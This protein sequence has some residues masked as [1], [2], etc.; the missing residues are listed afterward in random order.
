MFSLPPIP[1]DR[2][3]L[4]VQSIVPICVDLILSVDGCISVAEI[5][6]EYRLRVRIAREKVHFWAV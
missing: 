1:H 2:I 3:I 5:G 6:N 4:E